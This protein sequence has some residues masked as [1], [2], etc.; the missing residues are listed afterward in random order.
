MTRGS[1]GKHALLGP[2]SFLVAARAAEGRIETA[3]VEC[4]TERNGLHHVG[5][6]GWWM[7]E[8]IDVASKTFVV[9]VHDEI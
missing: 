1:E 5:V 8:R 9:G 2:R 3:G 4:L 7:I 6:D